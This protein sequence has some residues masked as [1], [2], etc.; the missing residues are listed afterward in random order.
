M[1]LNYYENGSGVQ[2]GE[3]YSSQGQRQ[4]AALVIR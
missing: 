2:S 3:C 4:T 1:P